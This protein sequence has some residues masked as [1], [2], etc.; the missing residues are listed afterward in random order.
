[1]KKIYSLVLLLSISYGF[2]QIPAGYYNAATGTGYTLKTQLKTIISTGHIDQGYNALWTL[3]TQSAWRDNYYENNGSLLD[4]Y[5]EKPAGADNYEYTSTSQQCGNYTAEGNCYNREHLVPQSYFDDFA[6]DPMKNDPFHVFPSDGKVNGDR[7]NLPFG[8]VASGSYISSNGSKRGSNT[9]NGYS[10]YSGTVFEPINEFKGDIAR[11][12]F[13]FATRYEDSMDDFYTA[14][15]G[16]TCEAKNMF[17]GSINK[18]FSDNF[19]LLLIKWHRQDP[20]SPKEIAQNNAIYT[21]QGNRNPYIDHPEYICNI[22]ASQ[23]ATVD[24]LPTE[25]FETL[26]NISIYP[27]PTKDNRINITSETELNEIQLIN[28]NGQVIKNI[29]KPNSVQNTYTL[30]NLPQGFYF[31]KLSSSDNQTT[32]RKILVN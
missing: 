14:A 25:S 5:S 3:Y 32:T 21:Y 16:A 11:A 31:V 28:I 13:Y 19:I 22:W 4:I 29:K 17:D 23:C 12:F 9:I 1:M 7:N 30:E 27:N 15:N 26:A 18:V 8:V 24:L 20:V 2:A 10:N 6:V